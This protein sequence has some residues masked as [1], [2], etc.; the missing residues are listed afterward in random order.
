MTD[1]VIYCRFSPRRNAEECDSCEHQAK[2]CKEYCHSKGFLVRGVFMDEDISGKTA[3][4]RQ[5]L[6]DAL[7]MACLTRAVV[8]VASLSR[9]AR[10]TMDAI[11]ISE[12]LQ[13]ADAGLVMLDNPELDR[14]TSS[15]RF[16]FTIM[17]SVAQWEREIIS[18]RTSAS[19]QMH[20]ISGKR[21]SARLP[22]GWAAHPTDADLM[23]TDSDEQVTIA[24]I[25]KLKAD[26]LTYG[27]IAKLFNDRGTLI[28]GGQWR[29]MTV[30]R[31]W[32]REEEAYLRSIA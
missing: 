22:F 2:R 31:I 8:V 14:S 30:E 26:G 6:Q 17:A 4:N 25:R 1:A 28:R 10:S 12:R 7:D 29:Y 15:G 3:K 13:K 11:T 32:K 24:E 20:Q 16:F 27:K 23:V 21:M 5:G 18:E 19:M 9:L